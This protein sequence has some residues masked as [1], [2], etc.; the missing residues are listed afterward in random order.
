[1]SGPVAADIDQYPVEPGVELGFVTKAEPCSECTLDCVLYGVLCLDGITQ[2]V[3]REPKG[4]PRS[5]VAERG[6]Y[7]IRTAAGRLTHVLHLNKGHTV[8]DT[9]PIY[10]DCWPARKVQ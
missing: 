4:R 5:P 2:Q 6:E 8:P 10:P 7:L 3:A 1:M 9:I